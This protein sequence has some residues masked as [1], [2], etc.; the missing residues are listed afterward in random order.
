MAISGTGAAL[1]A[2]QYARSSKPTPRFVSSQPCSFSFLLFSGF[3]SSGA[4]VTLIVGPVGMVISGQ[5]VAGITG[6]AFRWNSII[7]SKGI[8]FLGFHDTKAFCEDSIIGLGE[9]IV[10]PQIFITDT[11]H[12]TLARRIQ[13]WIQRCI[14]ARYFTISS[15]SR[16]SKVVD[17]DITCKMETLMIS[18]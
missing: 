9:A 17:P 1:L 15:D 3:G 13:G 5:T 4:T 7:K 2:R 14:Q 10:G 16:C 8:K 12:A 18:N 11:R 6:F